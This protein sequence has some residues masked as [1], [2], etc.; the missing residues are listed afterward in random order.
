MQLAMSEDKGEGVY[1][2]KS[3]ANSKYAFVHSTSSR[4]AY[5]AAARSDMLFRIA[6]E[7]PSL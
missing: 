4:V 7:K 1:D 5:V 6:S 2:A 3:G